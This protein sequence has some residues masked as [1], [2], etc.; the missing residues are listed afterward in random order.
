MTKQR[1]AAEIKEA[2]QDLRQK[3]ARALMA[4]EHKV[5]DI[6]LIAQGIR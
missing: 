3:R 5:L 6:I 4:L 2:L 1:R